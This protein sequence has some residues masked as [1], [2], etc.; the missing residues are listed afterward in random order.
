MDHV[1]LHNSLAEIPNSPHTRRI[2][3]ITLFKEKRSSNYI[4]SKV[5]CSRQT[6]HNVV[7]HFKKYG[8]VKDAPRSG[9]PKKTTPDQDARIME[10]TQENRWLAP[11][12][13]L[14]KIAQD[15]GIGMSIKTMHRRLHEGGFHRCVP[16]KKPLLTDKHMAIRLNWCWEREGWTLEDWNLVH[17]SDESRFSLFKKDGRK[18]VYRRCYEKLLSECITKTVKFDGGSVML[19]GWIS[20]EEGVGK[21]VECPK[22]TKDSPGM[23]AAAYQEILEEHYLDFH[24]RCAGIF[25]QDGAS[26]HTAKTTRKWMVDNGM[27]YFD[28]W[29]AQSPDLNPIEWLW[30]MV[31]QRVRDRKPLPSSLPVL[32]AALMEEWNNISL[33]EVREIL[34]TM[35]R[36]V[37]DVIAASGGYT[38]W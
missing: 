32:T 14:E 22:K 13:L 20:W 35:P 25:Q 9:R 37:Q 11:T 7:K 19:W 15:I 29:P 1:D 23:N 21:L 31:D 17:W 38:K 18:R 6:V 24:R 3:I 33:E 10:L 34:S 4:A 16:T 30:D 26:C 27:Q 12:L 5:P 28:V 8:H 36:R 2:K